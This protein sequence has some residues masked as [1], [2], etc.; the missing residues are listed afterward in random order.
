MNDYDAIN[1]MIAI[2]MKVLHVY[3]KTYVGVSLSLTF[4]TLKNNV[5]FKRDNIRKKKPW[6]SLYR[7]QFSSL[8]SFMFATTCLLLN[9]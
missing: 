1:F 8:R 9:M 4:F 7:W 2:I 3:Y 5:L 6:Y